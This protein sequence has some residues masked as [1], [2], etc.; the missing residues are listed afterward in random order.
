MSD[1]NHASDNAL[2]VTV[3]DLQ[4]EHQRHTHPACRY[5]KEVKLNERFSRFH[6]S[7]PSLPT[8]PC[9]IAR[10]I[11]VDSLTVA[12]SG[13]SQSRREEKKN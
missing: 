13:S 3:F 9:F 7:I 1:K 4:K 11:S 8:V 12:C 2:L 5:R 10:H 6:F